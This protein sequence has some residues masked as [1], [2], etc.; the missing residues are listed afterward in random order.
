MVNK[1]VQFRWNNYTE[2]DQLKELQFVSIQIKDDTDPLRLFD[3]IVVKY[4]GI[5]NF[6]YDVGGAELLIELPY[7]ND[8]R[9]GF[10][11]NL[12]QLRDVVSEIA[13]ADIAE[14]SL[15]IQLKRYYSNKIKQNEG[16]K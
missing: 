7:P 2:L 16:G 1:L 15:G 13:V 4:P 9:G 6:Y 12:T 14:L 10:G 8:E 5:K 3:Y 11:C